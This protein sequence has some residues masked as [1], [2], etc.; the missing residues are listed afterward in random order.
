MTD[1]LL[2]PDLDAPLRPPPEPEPPAAAPSHRRARGQRAAQRRLVR[3]GVGCSVALFTLLA[4]LSA[5]TT[6]IF[7]PP[8]EASHAGY[9]LEVAEGRL[10]TI[11][12]PIPSEGVPGMQRALQRRDGAHKTIWTANH[13]PLYYALTALPAKL[14]LD[15]IPGE[16]GLKS[17]RLLSVLFGAIAVMLVAALAAQLVPGRPALPVAAS[18][19]AA[20]VPAFTHYSGILY[21]DSLGVL[22]ATAALLAA[23]VTLRKGPSWPRLA[24]VAASASA[25]ALTRSSGLVVAAVACL[26]VL[27]ACWRS[28]PVTAGLRRRALAAS[29]H[30]TLVGITVAVT[31]GWFW[32]RNVRLYGDLTG[33]A[34]L[35]DRF[36]RAPDGSVLSMLLND[37]F[38]SLQAQRFLDFSY[39]NYAGGAMESSTV[40]WARWLLLIPLA[41]AAAI[42]A[43]RVRHRLVP[44]VR[45]PTP[46][47]F[48]WLASAVLLGLIEVSV[49]QFASA[50]GNI[51]GRYIMPALGLIA[52][53]GALG[54]GSLP[55]GRRGIPQVGLAAVLLAVNVA[56]LNQYVFWEAGT[57]PGVPALINTLDAVGLP[58]PTV[59]AAAG[60]A[61]GG[62][63]AVQAVV[64]W[65]LAPP[66]S[67]FALLR[68][69]ALR[70]GVRVGR[71]A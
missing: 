11:L 64:L 41:G 24:M 62:L 48:A 38:W 33:S 2:D 4:V 52:V 57:L 36:K 14:A 69:P 63:L 9:I 51:H 17:V 27:I 10:P 54:L 55:G 53:G 37:R 35:L 56:A 42:V 28:V 70:R 19:L 58:G 59:L 1:I 29:G 12:T 30:A 20:T 46:V 67:G 71:P 66:R 26:A 23:V 39:F 18:L 47:I 50:G 31:S 65:R 25:A 21:N 32:L 8:D 13:P 34:F 44:D 68:A 6:P 7:A 15:V 22:T 61:I 16:G 43:R 60:L 3:L 40:A 49:A 45:R 5:V